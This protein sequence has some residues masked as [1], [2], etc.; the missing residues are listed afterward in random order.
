MFS[1]VIGIA[2]VAGSLALDVFAVCVGV[3]VGGGVDRRAKVRIGFAFACSEVLMSV[4]GAVI[5]ALAGKAV[6]NVAGYAGFCAL[7]GVGVYT[8]VEAVRESEGS[9]DFSRGWGLVIASLS[10]SIDSLGIGF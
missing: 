10:I 9:F 6:G 1:S 3:G 4:V 7:I 8:I 2:L 5:G